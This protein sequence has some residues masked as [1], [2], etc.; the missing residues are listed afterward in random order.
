MIKVRKC[1]AFEDMGLMNIDM[2][3]HFVRVVNPP[4]TSHVFF[5]NIVLLPPQGKFATGG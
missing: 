1:I 5:S 3:M 4:T 2:S